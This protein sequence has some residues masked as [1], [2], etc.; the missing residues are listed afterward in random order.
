MKVRE[1]SS[2]EEAW[3][4][5]PKKWKNSLWK[6]PGRATAYAKASRF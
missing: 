4:R 3:G 6:G 2:E 1:V 5:Y